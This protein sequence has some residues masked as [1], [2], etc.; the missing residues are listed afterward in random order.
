MFHR[1]IWDLGQQVP[2]TN[3]LFKHPNILS[4]FEAERR[5]QKI[6]PTFKIGADTQHRL[7]I[8]SSLKEGTNPCFCLSLRDF[9]DKSNIIDQIK[10]ISI[11]FAQIVAYP[12]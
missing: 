9:A 12:I 5:P 6:Y 11:Q 1:L 4:V 2:C 8:E 3:T 7:L 10:I